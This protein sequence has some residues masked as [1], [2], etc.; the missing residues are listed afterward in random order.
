MAHC[1]GDAAS[2]QFLRL[3]DKVLKETGSTEELRPVMIHCQT[4]RNDQL[5]AMARFKMI[6]SIFVGHVWYWGD[7]HMKNFGSVRG[8]H[9]S[10]VR[11]AMDRGVT[12]NFHQDTPVTKPNML[13]SVWCAVNRIS[14]NGAVIG[15]NQRISV[16]EALKAVTINAAYE[17][18]EESSKGSIE[19][20]KRA[21]LVILD[22]S[23]LEV[24][25]MEIKNIQVMSTIK[26]G[27]VVYWRR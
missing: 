21:D 26:D 8:N 7:I 27:T 25:L 4:V 1:N 17:Y 10:P 19:A 18:F 12:V 9:I 3:Y 5:D 14:R 11:D 15:E 20:G 6:A 2:E 13:H 16:Y 22:K 23:P 24:D